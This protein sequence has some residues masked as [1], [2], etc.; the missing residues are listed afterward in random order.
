MCIEYVCAIMCALVLGGATNFAPC[1]YRVK[2]L[3]YLVVQ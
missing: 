1:K 3:R 2:I